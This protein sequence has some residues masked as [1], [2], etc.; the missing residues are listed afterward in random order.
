MGSCAVADHDELTFAKFF[1]RFF[2]L[3]ALVVRVYSRGYICIQVTA[4]KTGS[5]TV[6]LFVMRLGAG[7]F[8]QTIGIAVD[9][10]DIIHHFSKT[11]DT[12]MIVERINGPVIE[13]SPGLVHRA[14]RNTGR[15][16]EMHIDRES[17]CCL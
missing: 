15:K 6:Y 12:R 17:F 7:D 8:F 13:I 1:H 5:M 9:D 14:C 11:E 3:R 10:S 4:G 2:D 16:H